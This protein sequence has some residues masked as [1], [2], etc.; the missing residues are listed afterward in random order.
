MFGRIEDSRW[1][2]IGRLVLKGVAEI[3]APGSTMRP[4]CSVLRDEQLSRR[5][6]QSGDLS[7]RAV[8]TSSRLRLSYNKVAFLTGNLL[9]AGEGPGDMCD[10][11]HLL[12]VNRMGGQEDFAVLCLIGRTDRLY[13]STRR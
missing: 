2:E 6:E 7:R 11:E 8:V 13:R 12:R 4:M 10:E 1:L 3:L 9:A 5:R